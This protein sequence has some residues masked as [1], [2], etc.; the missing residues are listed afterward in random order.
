MSDAGRIQTGMYLMELLFF[1]D[2]FWLANN[3]EAPGKEGR[4]IKPSKNAAG[5]TK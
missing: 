4:R 3:L 5:I 2:G 1:L